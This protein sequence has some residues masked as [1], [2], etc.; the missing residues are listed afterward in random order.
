MQKLLLL[1]AMLQEERLLDLIGR[2]ISGFELG[3]YTAMYDSCMPCVMMLVF[4]TNSI[5]MLGVNC[6]CI[7]GCVQCALVETQHLDHELALC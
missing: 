6:M 3:M 1:V 2:D 7:S 4:I 5:K